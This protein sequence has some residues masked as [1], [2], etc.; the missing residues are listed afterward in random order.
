MNTG[1]QLG[2]SIGTSL[3]N[4]IA[5]GATTAYLTAHVSPRTLVHG[6]PSPALTGQALIHG[7]TTAFWWAA[8]IFACGAV[9][10]GLLFRWGPLVRP[11]GSGR[12]CPPRPRAPRS[13][14]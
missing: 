13:P 10:A 1:Q 8:V 6:R 12:S 9:V 2:G 4:T 5:A 7:Y 3:L 14:G 11:A